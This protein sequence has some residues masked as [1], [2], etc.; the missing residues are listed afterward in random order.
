[1]IININNIIGMV[2]SGNVVGQVSKVVS[3]GGMMQSDFFKLMIVQLQVQDFINLV[4][5]NQFVL[6]MVQFSQLQLSQ[7]MVSVVNMFNS[8]VN[9]VL[10]I[11][12]VFGL[13]NLVD[14]QV[15]VLV[16]MINYSGMVV[17]GVVNVIVLGKFIVNI[18]NV[19]GDVVCMMV[20]DVFSF[21]FIQFSWDGKDDVGNVLFLGSYK[22]VV[23]NG[24]SLFDI[25]VV[26][27][28]IVVGYGGSDVG[29]Y[30]Q[31]VGV[32]GVVFSQ[33]VQIF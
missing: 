12:Q 21:G 4:D 11:L 9:G 3:V 25:Y 8:I 29:I 20:V 7:D 26:G 14:C 13:F 32:G 33:V 31:V 27:K 16:L 10:Q 23:S 30:L 18:I 15:V 1:M 6:Q 22:M 19:N 28:V 24:G 2:G 5:N 17:S